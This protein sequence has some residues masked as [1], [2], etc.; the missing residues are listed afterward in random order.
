MMRLG[1]VAVVGFVPAVASA[2][3][4]DYKRAPPPYSIPFQLR[5]AA[6]PNAIRLDTMFAGHNDLAL[7]GEGRFTTVSI[8]NGAVRFTDHLGLVARV[9]I[10]GNRDGAAITNPAVGG[11]YLLTLSDELRLALFLGVAA[12]LG[13][14]GGNDP[15]PGKLAAINA[16]VLAR[17]AYDNALFGVNYL[18]VFPGASIAYVANNVT[19]QLEAT[20]LQ[21][22]RARG[23]DTQEASRTNFTSGLHVGYF[24][25]PQLSLGAE[26]RY[27][28]FLKNDVLKDK[29]GIDNF[30]FAAGVRGHFLIADKHWFR[31][32]LAYARGLDQPMTDLAYNIV[33]LD[34]LFIF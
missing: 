30:T 18:T 6:V 14:G 12:P 2:Q 28:R 10:A 33:Q 27:Q 24:V 15:N 29:P 34:L 26:L 13:Q 21:L 22:F 25:A 7:T 11:T 8:L 4:H 19:V 9:G 1:V 17:N 23:S 20:I 3:T 16:G 5:P 31:P 32:G